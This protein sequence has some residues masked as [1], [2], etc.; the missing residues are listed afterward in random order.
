MADSKSPAYYEIRIEEALDVHWSNWFDRLEV[1]ND[2]GETVI[3]GLSDEA[4][5]RG[6]LAK[7]LHLRQHLVAVRR[8]TRD[9]D[10]GG[11]MTW[12][13]RNPA[14]IPPPPGGWFTHAA[15]VELNTTELVF[16]SGQV[17]LDDQGNLIGKGDLTRQTEQVFAN[18]QLILADQGAT[19]GDVVNIRTYLTEISRIADYGVVRARYLT[20]PPPTSTTVQVAGLVHP[21]A[22]VEID[23]VFAVTHRSEA[24]LSSSEAP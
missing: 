18:L 16:V 22:L 19:F 23:I 9:P 4:A 7:V 20:A 11:S 10:K 1:R 5:L 24:D 15:R 13:P 12:L 14:T 3:Y 2:G 6:A 8:I 21:D 17:A